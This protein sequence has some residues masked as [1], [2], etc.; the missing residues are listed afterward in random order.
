MQLHRSWAPDQCP[1][2]VLDVSLAMQANAAPVIFQRESASIQ[3]DA[4]LTQMSLLV[5]MDRVRSQG[6]DEE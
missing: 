6:A 2:E 1:H 5:L 3:E 4:D